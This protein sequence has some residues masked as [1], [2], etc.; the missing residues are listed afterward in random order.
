MTSVVA[1]IASSV[2]VSDTWRA[3]LLVLGGLAALAVLTGLALRLLARLVNRAR[4]S[5]RFASYYLPAKA[6]YPATLRAMKRSADALIALAR[7]SPMRSFR[8]ALESLAGRP[9]AARSPAVR[10]LLRLVRVPLA[11]LKLLAAL[12]G[13]IAGGL[14]WLAGRTLRLGF[15]ALEYGVAPFWAVAIAAAARTARRRRRLDPARK[16]RLVWGPYPNLCIVDIARALENSGHVTH[17]YV[18]Y[19]FT[20]IWE[21]GIFTWCK[22]EAYKGWG[23]TA[24]AAYSRLFLHYKVFIDLIRAYDI[25]HG[26]FYP[27]YL[28]ET[29]LERFELYFLHLAGC[30]HIAISV[31]GDVAHLTDIRSHLIRHGYMEMYPHITT[32][33]QQRLI[34]KWIDHYC[35]HSD[36]V[37]AQSSYMID[38]LPRWDLLTNSYWPLDTELWKS[39][40]Y[41]DHDG[42]NAPVVIG[43]SPNHRPLKGT[44]FLIKAVNELRR[45]GLKITLELI[46]GKRNHEVRE[47]LSRCDIVVADLV[48]QGYSAMAIEGLALGRPVLQDISDPHYNRVYKLYSGLDQAPFVSVPLEEMKDRLRELVRN[49][50]LRRKIGREGRK[51]VEKFHSYEAV[52]K[53]W[54]WV[55]EYVWYGRR[56]RTAHYHP[57]WPVA[58]VSAGHLPSGNRSDATIA[59][60]ARRHLAHQLAAHPNRPVAVFPYNHATQ[61]VVRALVRSHVLKSSDYLIVGDASDLPGDADHL[62]QQKIALRELP[63]Y[64]IDLVYQIDTNSELEASLVSANLATYLYSVNDMDQAPYIPAGD[65]VSRRAYRRISL[66]YTSGVVPPLHY[67]NFAYIQHLKTVIGPGSRVADICSGPGTIGL[68][69]FKEMRLAELALI[70]IN[71]K[72]AQ[73]CRRNAKR[74]FGPDAPILVYQ[75]DVFQR[76]PKA[77]AW[78]VIVGNPPHNLDVH[79]L[80][81]HMP[82][83]EFLQ[84]HDA[85]LQFH[86]RFLAQAQ[87]RLP[88]GG[89]IIL[90]ENGEGGCVTA[91]HLGRLLREFPAYR[92]RHCEFL[93]SSQ[94]YVVEIERVARAADRT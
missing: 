80:G 3:V 86:R 45:E 15:R 16:P 67:S 20:R 89:R 37:F 53:F 34:K 44:N 79:G 7:Y 18:Y 2:S 9:A 65:S 71:P 5:A 40:H 76:V 74:N 78:D 48:L 50:R 51:Y 10:W 90:L 8:A 32:P 72:S 83:L 24:L 69:L 70:D 49:P 61:H 4:S 54:E 13:W 38:A 46:E 84:A 28:R 17:S 35:E 56:E 1:D 23:R 94:F 21:D 64:A 29:P 25:F 19:N 27:G 36:F 59:A 63:D 87:A 91:G 14:A 77:K 47:I 6:R 57:D 33:S 66:D 73:M 12:P 68:S 26:N 58:T 85:N 31:G 22:T 43:H 11:P 41:S 75:S 52:A 93:P 42:R 92:M 60:D 39:S 82:K 62:P 88:I 81:R 30:K 55:Y